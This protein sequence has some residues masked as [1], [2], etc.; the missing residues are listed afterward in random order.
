MTGGVVQYRCEVRA[1]LHLRLLQLA[2]AVICCWK[3]LPSWWEELLA[4]VDEVAVRADG[5]R[6]GGAGT[7]GHSACE[8]RQQRCSP[9]AGSQ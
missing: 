9:E 2:C 8:A 7:D 4:V 6:G 1:D 5:A 3:F